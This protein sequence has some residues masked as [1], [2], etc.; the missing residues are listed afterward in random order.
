MSEDQ[1]DTFQKT[2]NDSESWPGVLTPGVQKYTVGSGRKGDQ[3]DATAREEMS[4]WEDIHPR[5]SVQK[6][7]MNPTCKWSPR[8]ISNRAMSGMS[9]TLYHEAP[10]RSVICWLNA[11]KKGDAKPIKT[12]N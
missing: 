12:W 10:E 8:M 11:T 9:I 7:S 2:N 4:T 5:L 6:K 1:I 3:N